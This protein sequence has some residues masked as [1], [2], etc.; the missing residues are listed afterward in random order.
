VQ[1]AGLA[2]HA[3]MLLYDRRGA[4]ESPLP[5][6]QTLVTVEAHAMDA[7]RLIEAYGPGPLVACG[8]SFGAVVVLE[9]ARRRPELLRGMVLLEPPLPPSDAQ[10]LLPPALWESLERTAQEEGGPAATEAFLRYVLGDED[11]Q[12]MPR[13]ARARVLGRWESIRRDCLALAAYRVDY[14]GLQAVRTPALLLGGERSPPQYAPTLAALG[15]S[16]ARAQ[17]E[18]VPG[19]GHML[20]ADVRGYFNRRVL[21]F[22]DAVGGRA[23]ALRST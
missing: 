18:T 22:M 12:R 9:L 5:E 3:R 11:L 21:A 13:L 2:A 23:S 7:A 16:L 6:G 17:L 15:R 19:M 10:A 14:A 20:Q 4:G 8:S 1:R